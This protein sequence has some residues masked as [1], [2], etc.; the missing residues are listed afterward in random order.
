M[1]ALTLVIG[2]KNY[3]SWSLRP[4]LVMKMAGVAFEELVI[5]L[6]Q[7][8]TVAEIERH[9]PGGR[10]PALR[11]GELVVWESI[12]IA[13]ISPRRSRRRASGRGSEKRA[14]SPALSRPRCTPASRRCAP[15][16]R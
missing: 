4:W 14:P 16:C 5:P 2:N 7:D 15:T 12:A 8:A 3:S 13:N 10:V 1:S 6:R 9:S 11:H